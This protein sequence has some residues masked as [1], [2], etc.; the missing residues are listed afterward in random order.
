MSTRKKKIIRIVSLYLAFNLLAQICWPTAAFALTNGPGQPEF[1]S[2]E[3]TGTTEMVNLFTGD[4]NYNIPLMNVPG[5]N[6]GYPINLAYHAGISMEQEASWVGLGWNINA[7]AIN[8]AMRGLP[9]DFNGD[10][11]V[12]KLHFKPNTSLSLSMGTGF[13]EVDNRHEILGFAEFKYT[14]GVNLSVYY[15]NYRGIGYG[16]DF[17]LSHINVCGDEK[18]LPLSLNLSGSSDGIGVN[19]NYTNAGDG[20]IKHDKG[21]FSEIGLSWGSRDGITSLS[22]GGGYQAHKGAGFRGW[23]YGGG[24]S[25]SKCSYVPSST[26]Q[27]TGIIAD[28]G[29][30]F[31]PLDNTWHAAKNSSANLS[32]TQSWAG[33]D[34]QSS[35]GWHEYAV[36]YLHSESIDPTNTDH[37]LADVNIEKDA[38]PVRQTKTLG[39]PVST[40]DVFSVSGQGVGGSFRPYRSDI[41]ILTEPEITSRSTGGKFIPEFGANISGSEIHWGANGTFNQSETYSGMWYNHF[42]GTDNTDSWNVIEDFKYQKKNASGAYD[43]D[44][45][46]HHYEPY[47]FKMSGEQT[48]SPSGQLDFAG[49][50]EAVRFDLHEKYELPTGT[51]LFARPEL[52]NEY[53]Y[54]DDVVNEPAIHP[55]LINNHRHER[56]K[57]VVSNQEYTNLTLQQLGDAVPA[58]IYSTAN[59]FPA[60]SSTASASSYDYSLRPDNHIGQ[61]TEVNPDGNR[62]VY[63]LPVYNNSSTE[64]TFSKDRAPLQDQLYPKEYKEGYTTTDASINNDQ[65]HENYFSSTTLPGY[66]E[67]YL[68]TAIYSPDYVDVTGNGPTEDDLGYYVKFNY[69]KAA[70]DFKW[71][72]PYTQAILDPRFLSN[73]NDDMLSYQYGTKELYYLHS[74][75]SKTHVACFFLQSDRKDGHSASSEDAQSTAFGSTISQMSLDHISLYSKAD[76][77]YGTSHAT[78][79]KSVYFTYDY[80]LCPNVKNNDGSSL[81]VGTEDLNT[82]KGKL[83]LKSIYFTYLDNNKG[84]LS[85]YEFGYDDASY[86]ADLNNPVYDEEG[87][88]RWGTYKKQES[89]SLYRNKENPYVDQL[90]S[91]THQKRVDESAAAWCLKQITL[92]SGST[93]KVN[94][95]ADDYAYVQ[96]YRATQMCRVVGTYDIHASSIVNTGISNKIGRKYRRIVFELNKPV[97]TTDVPNASD[98]QALIDKYASGMNEMYFKMF[99]KLKVSQLDLLNPVYDYV[100]GYCELDSDPS[101]RGLVYDASSS[102]YKYGYIT[103]KTVDRDD[104][105]STGSPID[106]NPIQKAGWQY[107][108]LDRPDLFTQNNIAVGAVSNLVAAV[109]NMVADI[110]RAVLPYTYADVRSWCNEIDINTSDPN[111]ECTKRPSWIRLYSPDG[112][113]KGG[114]HR[115]KSIV[116]NDVWGDLSSNAGSESKYGISYS[117]RLT[118]GRSSGVASYEPMIGGDEIALRKPIRYN[119]NNLVKE[120]AAFYVEEPM[121]ESYFPAPVVGYSRVVVKSIVG[122]AD[123]DNE[124]DRNKDD[125]GH[126]ISVARA[127]QTVYEFYT[128]KDY[129]VIC[130]RTNL[131]K[132]W[133]PVPIY[134]PFMGAIT[135]NTRGFS[136]GY[137]VLLNDMHGKL[138]AVSTYPFN[139]DLSSSPMPVRRVVYKYSD[140][141][142]TGGPDPSQPRRIL[143]NKVTVLTADGAYEESNLGETYDFFIDMHQHSNKTLKIGAQFNATTTTISGFTLPVY[144]PDIEFSKA[145]YRSIVAMKV[146]YRTGILT[147][148]ETMDDGAK[149]TATNLMFDAETGTPLLT[150]VTNEFEKPI[151]TYNYAAHWSYKG[152][153]GAYQN[154]GVKF[155]G[156]SSSGS[157]ATISGADAYFFPGDEVLYVPD[158]GGSSL[159]LWV[160]TVS[161]SSVTL[162]QRDGTAPSLSGTGTYTIIRSGHRNQQV[163]SNGTIVSLSN[164]VTN[165]YFPLFAA[166]SALPTIA[167]ATT[168]SYTDCDGETHHF[169]FS[170]VSGNQVSIVAT[171]GDACEANLSFPESF[172]FTDVNQLAGATFRKSGNNIIVTLADASTVT[173]TW[174]DPGHCFNECLDDVLHAAAVRFSDSWTMNFSDVG[175]TS[176]P[177]SNDY[178]LAQK[179]VWRTESNYLYQVDRKQSNKSGS[180]T[181]ISYDGTYKNF[182]LYDWLAD[183]DDNS[184][185]SYVS[186]VSRYSPYGYALESRDALGIY[187]STMFGYSN[188]KQTA[189]AAN[190]QYFEMGYDGFEDYGASYPEMISASPFGHGHLLFSATTGGA[191]SLYSPLAHTGKYSLKVDYGSPTNFE[192]HTVDGVYSTTQ[193]YFEPQPGAEYNL[194]VWVQADN[195]GTPAVQ[196]DNGALTVQYT[197]DMSKSAIEGWRR[198]D[199][200]FT[201][202]ATSSD[203]KITLK[204]LDGG[205][206]YFDDLRIQPFKSAM[207]SY[208]YDP[209]THW[210][211]AE[212]DNRNFAT[213][214]NYDEE[215]SV[216]QVKQETEKGIFTV[217]TG[218]SNIKRQ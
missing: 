203:L 105:P 136:Q 122:N 165:R 180:V 192:S 173:A 188:T 91:G 196:V 185:W 189:A 51:E 62:Y 23:P 121:G 152:M 115:V 113:K 31:G 177:T 175:L 158:A 52:L 11:V 18:C 159:H 103:V 92:P 102:Q 59:S 141:P 12:K 120:D 194:T 83:T 100:T 9:D 197:P 74:I 26:P 171:D 75:E 149:S 38:P 132:T 57:R 213:F 128:A 34:Y 82:N 64:V 36:G 181:D 69:F 6:G 77:N 135:Y 21:W 204:C 89:S 98:R 193:Q 110:P 123:A 117:Y 206:A 25:F 138:K 129:P 96:D 60:T 88:D 156:V 67:S 39:V 15:N 210:L 14:L 198:I 53:L 153:Q 125:E 155:G 20:I 13:Q 133:F 72:A 168:Y 191:P 3:P 79:L 28:L 179:G 17:G 44:P 150:S 46:D 54:T 107:L 163:A 70:S 151:Y 184:H 99:T 118:D 40:Y 55:G 78:P 101:T 80:S 144:L 190:C 182:T 104:Y 87:N 139:A 169:R 201:A 142:K 7:G 116:M 24:V 61:F 50:T 208:V 106:A 42:W 174:S 131:Q 112:I 157:V 97:A 216:V 217:K 134:L 108:Y 209:Q 85:P 164:P 202:P 183:A 187:S 84:K 66:A 56:E 65:G 16:Y 47:Y 161:S 37:V 172:V 140:A 154:I 111:F 4:F 114:G 63:G 167:S 8:R 81:T 43:G 30:E 127:G 143:D 71:R 176:L 212:L 76:P 41:G 137:S 146:I 86:D 147:S 178:V 119:S 10:E 170:T 22:L 27:M 48:A 35:A 186:E 19:V 218:R 160:S 1:Q 95:E 49:G 126:A 195:G 130:D 93:I 207:T 205:H 162:M 199:F 68:L 29:V 145:L 73:P 45:T 124:E 214:Y 215:G 5:P 200:K 148:V 32:W 109:G 90:T 33:H 211:L 58:N 2:F 166:I 94:Y